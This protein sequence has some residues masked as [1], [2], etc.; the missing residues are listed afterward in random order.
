MANALDNWVVKAGS[1]EHTMVVTAPIIDAIARGDLLEYHP[2]DLTRGVCNFRL[3]ADPSGQ[4]AV[5]EV[6][7]PE[8]NWTDKFIAVLK[9]LQ[10]RVVN[11]GLPNEHLLDDR[12]PQGDANDMSGWKVTKWTIWRT[13]WDGHMDPP[14][15]TELTDRIEWTN[16][17]G[18]VAASSYIWK[19][20]KR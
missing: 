18:R 12:V 16:A 20:Y 17:E 2:T 6:V 19:P 10:L 1:D 15:L 14:E 5:V 13:R 11:A 7:E 3:R 4:F 8:R 9:T